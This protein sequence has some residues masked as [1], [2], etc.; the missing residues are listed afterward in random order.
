M[1]TINYLSGF[2]LLI[3]LCSSCS[4]EQEPVLEENTAISLQVAP[5]GHQTTKASTTRAAIDEWEATPISM[6]YR[7][8]PDVVYANKLDMDVPDNAT[9]HLLDTGLDYASD[10]THKVYLRGFY[11]QATPDE[12]G[13]VSYNLLTADTDVMMSNEVQGS[14]DDPFAPATDPNDIIKFD[15]LLTRLYFTF[16]CAAGSTYPKRVSGILIIPNTLTDPVAQIDLDLNTGTVAWRQAG[17]PFASFDGGLTVPPNGAKPVPVLDVMFRPEVPFQIYVVN[18]DSSQTPV[19]FTSNATDN[20]ITTILANGGAAHTRY[21]IDLYFSGNAI[22]ANNISIVD[23][24]TA[25][26]TSVTWH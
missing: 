3:L 24:I 5:L 19:T 1:S 18:T 16:Q 10:R 25:P 11:P 20:G 4:G 7:F 12:D 14:L 9:P 23:W 22:I 6:A 17:M 15:H 2:A 13:V 21:N 26:A 8:D